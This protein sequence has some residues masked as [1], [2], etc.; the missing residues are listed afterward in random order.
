MNH[1]STM[2][3][4]FQSHQGPHIKKLLGCENKVLRW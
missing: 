1:V 2:V 3:E 4:T